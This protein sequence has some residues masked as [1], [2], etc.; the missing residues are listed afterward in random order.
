MEKVDAIIEAIL[1]AILD[2]TLDDTNVGDSVE[3][4]FPLLSECLVNS[5]EAGHHQLI[6]AMCDSRLGLGLY[7]EYNIFSDGFM[8]NS[9]LGSKYW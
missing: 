5:C 8:Q 6:H 1:D 4:H 3:F 7:I 2:A 9:A